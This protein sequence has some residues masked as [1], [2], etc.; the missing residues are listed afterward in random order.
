MAPEYLPSR[1]SASTAARQ[2]GREADGSRAAGW[3]A[4]G[5]DR[6]R[7]KTGLSG[8]RRARLAAAS[9]VTGPV[10]DERTS[11]RFWAASAL[12]PSSSRLRMKND[13]A[14]VERFSEKRTT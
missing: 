7:R 1:I 2:G 3:A 8:K 4:S 12:A 10:R 6:K 9:W 14:S 13:M 11:S 5:A